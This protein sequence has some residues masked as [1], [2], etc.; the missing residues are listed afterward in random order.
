M[1]LPPSGTF[2]SKWLLLNSAVTGG[3]WALAVVVLVGSL[4]AAIYI[5][6]VVAKA[7][8]SAEAKPTQP[9]PLVMQWVPLILALFSL[10]LGLFALRPLELL[11]VG[12]P[13]SP[14]SSGG[15]T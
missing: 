9:V 14:I 1:G 2:L 7:F 3:R 11:E 12:A 5:F 8:A 10:A 4:M 6:R 15:T 13:F